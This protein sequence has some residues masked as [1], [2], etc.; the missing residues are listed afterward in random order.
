MASSAAIRSSTAGSGAAVSVELFGVGAVGDIAH[1]LLVHA[2]VGEG[3]GFGSASEILLAPQ[4]L[5]NVAST[6]VAVAVAGIG[7]GVDVVLGALD[8]LR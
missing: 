2:V 6:E 7:P 4:A 3:V 5:K 8:E 1:L